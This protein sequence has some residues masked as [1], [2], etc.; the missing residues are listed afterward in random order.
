MS[1]LKS[2]YNAPFKDFHSYPIISHNFCRKLQENARIWTEGRGGGEGTYRSGTVNSKS[3][4]GKVLLRI[5]WK[6]ELN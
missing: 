1:Q 4:V 6:F 3:F 5:K 2:I